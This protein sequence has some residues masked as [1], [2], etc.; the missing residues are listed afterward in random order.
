MRD[1]LLASGEVVWSGAGAISRSDGW[2][3]LHT[4]DTAP[5]SLAAP[6]AIEFTDRHRMVLD[7]LSHGGGFFFRQLADGHD[8]E[9]KTGLWELVWAGWVTG[10]TFAPVRALLA[11]SRRGGGR[12]TPAHRSR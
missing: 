8:D 10:D 9:L 3:A 12:S 7:T 5:L 1:E 6:A 2:I 11:G 4:A